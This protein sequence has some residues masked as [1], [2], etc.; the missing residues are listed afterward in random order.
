M[1]IITYA[2]FGYNKTN[3]NC[4]DFYTYLRGLAI[5]IRLQRLLLPD[6]TINLQTDKETYEAFKD[7]F[8]GYKIEINI[9]EPAPLCLAM[10]WRM[11]PVFNTNYTHVLCRDLD[12][13]LTYRE[14]QCV[15]HWENK[16]KA[17]HAITDSISHNIPMLGGMIG[18]KT[19]VFSQYT[20]F[21][22]W[23]DMVHNKGINYDIKGSDQDL[24][25]RYVYPHFAQHGRDSI[26]QHYM[27]GMPNTFLSDYHSEVPNIELN[28]PNEYAMKESNDCAVHIGQ[29]GWNET[30]TFKFLRKHWIDFEQEKQYKQIFYWYAS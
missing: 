9:N 11:K 17:A 8:D 6:Y 18:F 19:N 21:P 16:N 20:G 5:N 1:K 29:A 12:S 25:N 15:K 4:F 23:E 24:L 26:T 13:P 22:T 27:K 14:A 28:I 7:L 2:L 10:L 30:G 3:E